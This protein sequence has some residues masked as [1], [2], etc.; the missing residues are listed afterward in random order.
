MV[1]AKRAIR[2]GHFATQ[3]D[4]TKAAAIFAGLKDI[5]PCWLGARVNF[6]PSILSLIKTQTWAWRKT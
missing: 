4:W 3:E 2:V 5:I 6:S 1:K